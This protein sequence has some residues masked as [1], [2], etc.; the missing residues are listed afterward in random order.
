MC[1]GVFDLVHPGHILHFKSARAHGDLLVVTLTKDDYVFKGPGRPYFN[2][3]LRLESIAALEM[4]DYV[5]LNEW[6]I[7]VETIRQ[8][9]PDFYAKG[10]DYAKV[11]QDV[12]GNI[13]LE[14]AA[15][16]EVGGKV[17]YTDEAMFSSSKLINTYFPNHPEKTRGF[18]ETFKTK[19]TSESVVSLLRSLKDIKVLV[20]GEAILDQY[21]YCEPLAKTPKDII[22]SGRF[23]SKEDFA[24]GT[25]AVANHLANFCKEVTLVTLT[26]NEERTL[27]WFRS[28]LLPNVR[29][30]PVMDGTRPTIVKR[31]FM[32]TDFLKKMFELQYLNDD[33]LGREVE[34]QVVDSLSAN[35]A[36]ADLIVA[37]DFGHGMMTG[38]IR[39]VLYNSGKF[40]ALNTQSN[41]ANMGFNPVT[42]YTHADY[43]A[44]DEPELR[45]ASHSKYGK[46]EELS[47]QIKKKLEAGV[48][49]VS[50]GAEG[51]VLIAPDGKI[52]K[53]PVFSQ[54]VVDRTGAG[55][56]LFAVTSPCVYRGFQAEVIGF[57][58]NCVGA[59]AVETVCNREPI[60]AVKLFKFITTL[61]K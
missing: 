12:T 45:F 57:V 39:E 28:K 14:V 34:N 30:L 3:Q 50:L 44:I 10:S 41:S 21:Y 25:L 58:A 60:D 20:V 46:I 26:G 22:V 8:L 40:L 15:V 48:F 37:G 18:L 29:F 17:I 11:E 61:L 49:M 32:A 47:E 52:V 7:S 1:H 24:G 59:L 33:D 36:G 42:S 31:R 4:V 16:K 51:N 56:A 23:V 9:K 27:E 13:A 43:V 55:D 5:A 35:L 54:H 53:T 38:K 2:Q 19:Y 6:P